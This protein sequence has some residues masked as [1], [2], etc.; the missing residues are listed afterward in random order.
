MVLE[1][2][3]REP[4]NIYLRQAYENENVFDV[5]VTILHK[6]LPTMLTIV[7]TGA[8]ESFYFNELLKAD[9]IYFCFLLNI[10]Q[11]NNYSWQQIFF[12]LPIL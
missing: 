2:N 11:F 3:I 10:T 8:G 6:D 7:S 9:C 4:R 12:Y 5:K 1:T